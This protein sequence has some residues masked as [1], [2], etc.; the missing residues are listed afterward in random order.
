VGALLASG[1]ALGMLLPSRLGRP[2]AWRPGP[3]SLREARG[4]SRDRYRQLQSAFLSATSGRLAR[5][6][7]S[8]VREMYAVPGRWPCAE[9]ARRVLDRARRLN[10]AALALLAAAA[11]GEFDARRIVPRGALPVKA[12]DLPAATLDVLAAALPPIAVP[13]FAGLAAR[14]LPREGAVP[15]EE[16]IDRYQSLFAEMLGLSSQAEV[17]A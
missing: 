16:W 8:L 14:L 5:G 4:V 13:D 17:R 3:A 9:G 15:G 11:R 1:A 6:A 12:Y 10:R 2:G 7:G